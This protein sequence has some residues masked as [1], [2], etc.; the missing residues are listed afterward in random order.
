MEKLI[1]IVYDFLIEAIQLS[2]FVVLEVGVRPVRLKQA[3]DE[4]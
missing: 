3:G 4:G 1:E 2:S